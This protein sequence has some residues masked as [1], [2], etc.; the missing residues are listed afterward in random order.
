M[1]TVELVAPERLRMTEREIPE[2]GPGEARVAIETVGLCGTDLEFYRGRRSAGYPFVL[3]H[4]C[5][6]RID[7]IGP[8]VTDWEIGSPVAVRPNFGCGTCALCLEGRD[9]LCPDGRGLGV[10]IDGCLSEHVVVPARYLWPVPDGMDLETAAL[11]EPIAV[12]E[13]AVRRAGSVAGRRLLVLGAGPIGL[14]ALQIARI[15]GAEVTVAD[16]IPER[17]RWALDLG[18]A[19]AFASA[20]NSMKGELFDVVIETAGVAETAAASVERARP[21][22]WIVLTGIPMDPAPIETRWV[23]WREL[24]LVGSF[25]YEASDFA[26]ASDRVERGELHVLDLVTDRFAIDR[27]SE[28]FRVAAGRRGLKVLIKM[29][30]EE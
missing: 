26:R 12:A 28:A 1:K 24:K 19:R 4:E 30:E 9:N 5:A 21:G 16:P 8:E 15:A 29:R 14:L 17:R 20:S 13:R 7:A 25:I 18:A 11:I 2:P 3:G 23:V 10:K 22:G 6:G 27:T